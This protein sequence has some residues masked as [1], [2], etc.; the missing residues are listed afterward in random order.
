MCIDLTEHGIMGKSK[1]ESE[2]QMQSLRG[3]EL[4][5][6]DERVTARTAEHT[7]VTLIY[8]VLLTI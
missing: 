4:R 1:S 3:E 2:R 6:A 5:C 8:T 7:H